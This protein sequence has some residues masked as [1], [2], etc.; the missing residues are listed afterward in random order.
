MA[1]NDLAFPLSGI[2]D[3]PEKSEKVFGRAMIT[4]DLRPLV[5]WPFLLLASVRQKSAV[6]NIRYAAFTGRPRHLVIPAQAGIGSFDFSGAR[7]Q[8]SARRGEKSFAPA[9]QAHWGGSLS[10]SP[11]LTGLKGKVSNRSW[12]FDEKTNTPFLQ[13]GKVCSGLFCLGK[14]VVIILAYGIHILDLLDLGRFLGVLLSEF[15]EFFHVLLGQ[16]LD[17][18]AQG[19][20][21]LLCLLRCTRGRGVRGKN[22]DKSQDSG[23]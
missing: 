4:S 10:S 22:Q 2:A 23:G 11:M 3:R 19:H 21:F 13:A 9:I 17:L 18:A 12:F 20:G 1:R 15:L 16:R 5:L 7:N 14:H 8:L 6:K